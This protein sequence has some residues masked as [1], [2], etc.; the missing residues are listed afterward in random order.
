MSFT[1]IVLCKLPLAREPGQPATRFWAGLTVWGNWGQIWPV[2]KSNISLS[3]NCQITSWIYSQWTYIFLTELC[4]TGQYHLETDQDAFISLIVGA[5]IS[6]DIY[7]GAAIDTSIWRPIL[8]GRSSLVNYNVS[9]RHRTRPWGQGALSHY[10]PADRQHGLV[11]WHTM[12]SHPHGPHWMKSQCFTSL[13]S[14]HTPTSKTTP[15]SFHF[16]SYTEQFSR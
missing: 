13:S 4:V 9:T 2:D 14:I 6:P 5:M 11:V 3:S 12:R 15:H 1:K 8:E 7:N 10:V 16:P